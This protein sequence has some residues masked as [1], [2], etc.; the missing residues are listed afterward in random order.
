MSEA[1]LLPEHWLWTFADLERFPEDGNRYEII[2]GSLLVSPGPPA[3]HQ[4]VAGNLHVLLAAA[5]P[6][7][8]RVT[9]GVGV[10]LD[11]DDATQYLIPDVLVVDRAVKDVLAYQPAEV[12]L[13]VEVVSPSS[14]TRD[15]VTSGMCTPVSASPAIGSSRPLRRGESPCSR[16]L[17]AGP[18]PRRRSL[19]AR[20][21]SSSTGRSSSAS[22]SRPCW[23]SWL[24]L[25]VPAGL[26][27]GSTSTWSPIDRSRPDLKTLPHSSP[28]S[29]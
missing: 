7:A 25:V 18:M 14:V 22:R 13:A 12:H 15:R 24:V 3:N 21:S 9:Q 1:L 2:D 23:H 6:S 19:W 28:S 5:A 26:A 11:D 10:L 4:S 27:R 16:P 29:T 20:S 17:A 8:M